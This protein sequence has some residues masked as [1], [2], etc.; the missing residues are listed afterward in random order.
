MRGALRR[1]RGAPTTRADGVSLRGHRPHVHPVVA[2]QLLLVGEGVEL[3]VARVER[4]RRVALDA[5][6]VQ[7]E[8]L[9][10]LRLV[11]FVGLE[12]PDEVVA[13]LLE[14]R[15]GPARASPDRRR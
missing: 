7:V 9:R 6:H 2:G 10:I 3:A 12:D 8:E 15:A 5:L 4:R 13:A 14:Q 11:F 1:R